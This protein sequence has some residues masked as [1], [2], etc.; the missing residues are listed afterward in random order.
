LNGICLIA[1]LLVAPLGDAVT[2]RWTHSIE[3]ILWE[4]DYRR[5][6]DVLRLVEARVRGTGAGM[7][8]PTGAVLRDGVWRYVPDLPSLPG[9]ILRHSPHVPPYVA[10]GDAGC[11][12]VPDWLPGLPAD[13][14]LELRPCAAV[15]PGPTFRDGCAGSSDCRSGSLPR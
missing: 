8:P 14:L 4:E 2:L 3:K 5:E 11:R 7:E 15:L 13:A 9:V 1:G 10:C 6:G 12:S